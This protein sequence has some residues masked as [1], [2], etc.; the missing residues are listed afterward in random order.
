MKS[1]T[2]PDRDVGSSDSSAFRPAAIA[3]FNAFAEALSGE[4]Q[5][6]ALTEIIDRHH[7]LAAD[8]RALLHNG[9]AGPNYS[10]IQRAD[11]ILAEIAGLP[12][13]NT[14]GQPRP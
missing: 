9:G 2:T 3:A 10:Q 1:M 12:S 13:P 5:I 7:R 14:Q 6:R 8:A 11:K 4:P